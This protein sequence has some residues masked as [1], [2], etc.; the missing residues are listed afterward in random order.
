M[1]SIPL[2]HLLLKLMVCFADNAGAGM[3]GVF[4][5][6][7]IFKSGNP[8][9]R[10]KAMVL[11]VTNYKDAKL[12]A[13]VGDM[14]SSGR[15]LCTVRSSNDHTTYVHFLMYCNCKAAGLCAFT[16]LLMDVL[17]VL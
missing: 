4:V 15:R 7:G 13:E 10:A 9:E 6:S 11:A 1:A 14:H 5:G 12:L 17:S 8:A 16:R 3:D 2:Y